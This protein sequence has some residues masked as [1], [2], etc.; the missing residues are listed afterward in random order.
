MQFHIDS[1]IWLHYWF[2]S[3]IVFLPIGSSICLI[4]SPSIFFLVSQLILLFGYFSLL[5]LLFSKM[6]HF[7]NWFWLPVFMFGAYRIKQVYQ[8]I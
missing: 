7:F 6:V 2:I 4:I 8:I 3:L 5:V 1:S